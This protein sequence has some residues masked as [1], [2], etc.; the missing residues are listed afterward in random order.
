MP[1][2]RVPVGRLSL[3]IATLF[4]SL[5]AQAAPS[6]PYPSTYTVAPAA[7]VLIQGATVLTGT[8]TV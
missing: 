6:D 5:V 8:R 7:P 3:L 1:A 4:V 2:N